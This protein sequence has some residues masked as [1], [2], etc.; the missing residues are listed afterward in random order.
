MTNRTDCDPTRRRKQQNMAAGEQSADCSIAKQ[1]FEHPST[2]DSK[3]PVSIG[4]CCEFTFADDGRSGLIMLDVMQPV[5]AFRYFL[6]FSYGVSPL[7][8]E[9]TLNVRRLACSRRTIS[10]SPHGCRRR[11]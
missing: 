4:S 2:V 3:Q 6:R 5:A 7:L 8:K 1:L 11:R 10:S 9:S